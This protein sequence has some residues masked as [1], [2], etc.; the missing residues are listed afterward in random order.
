MKKR[1]PLQHAHRRSRACSDIRRRRSGARAALG[2]VVAGLAHFSASLGE[3]SSRPF[4][5][6]VGTAPPLTDIRSIPRT[7]AV[8]GGR[9]NLL[10]GTSTVWTTAVSA[11]TGT[12]V[13]TSRRGVCVDGYTKSVSNV[14]TV[15]WSRHLAS[16]A[17]AAAALLP[18]T[19]SVR[20]PTSVAIRLT[21]TLGGR[22]VVT[23]EHEVVAG[24]SP[25]VGG[26]GKVLEMNAQWICDWNCG[27][28]G[29]CPACANST[30]NR[31]RRVV[32]SA[33][34]SSPARAGA[35]AI[36]LFDRGSRCRRSRSTSGSSRCLR[37]S[38]R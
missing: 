17:L 34:P 25:Q 37:A 12:I 30:A 8:R 6:A 32:C 21:D 15:L 7:G 18:I 1:R 33:R 2:R 28:H 4:A 24:S 23:D 36:G 9:S 19:S 26:S 11:D 22:V 3:M 16:A 29:S 5:A 13:R 14:T 20:R 35:V 10:S 31:A 27:G 38:C